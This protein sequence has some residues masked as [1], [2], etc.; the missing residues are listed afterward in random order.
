MNLLLFLSLVIVTT[1]ANAAI[2]PRQVPGSLTPAQQAS[3][4]ARMVTLATS[5]AG[6]RNMTWD[7]NNATAAAVKITQQFIDIGQELQKVDNLGFST[8]FATKWAPF[9]MVRY[10]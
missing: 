2:L 3:F 8:N 5:P 1:L 9:R 7:V 10:L 4:H 6:M